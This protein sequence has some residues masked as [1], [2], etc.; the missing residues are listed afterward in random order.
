MAASATWH[1]S[2]EYGFLE[3]DAPVGTPLME[4]LDHLTLALGCMNGECEVSI[5]MW[6]GE[7]EGSRCAGRSRGDHKVALCCPS[8]GGQLSLWGGRPH[9][10][11]YRG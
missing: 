10:A 1:S 7:E 5:D 8:Y 6:D 11:S 9:R 2:R 4:I 3:G